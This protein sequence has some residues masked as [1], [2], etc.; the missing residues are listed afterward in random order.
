MGIKKFVYLGTFKGETFIVL[1]TDL[2]L[3]EPIELFKEIA[4]N[5]MALRSVTRFF[6]FF[7][8]DDQAFCDLAFNDEKFMVFFQKAIKNM[9][10]YRWNRAASQIQLLFSN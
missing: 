3:N 10:I 7:T 8:L 4:K 1:E 6:P 9:P 2:D 5:K